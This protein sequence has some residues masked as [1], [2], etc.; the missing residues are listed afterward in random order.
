MIVS[1]EALEDLRKL[2]DVIAEASAL[3]SA[4]RFVERITDYCS[5]LDYGAE[6]GRR[7]D[8]IRPG[9]RIVGFEARVT[10]AFDLDEERATILRIFSRGRNWEDAF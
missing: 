7:R 2:Y 8:D 6:R 1:P 9:L 3:E 5:R 4:W 10:I